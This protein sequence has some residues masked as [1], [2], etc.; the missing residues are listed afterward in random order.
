MRPIRYSEA[1]Q[2]LLRQR[3]GK[4][5][6]VLHI[7]LTKI[8]PLVLFESLLHLHVKREVSVNEEN[9]IYPLSGS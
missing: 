5:L 9:G 3:S 8:Q 6:V 7:R 4:I 1:S 2:N